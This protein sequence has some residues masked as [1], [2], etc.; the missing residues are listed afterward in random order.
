MKAT[1][2]LVLFH[3]RTFRGVLSVTFP[4]RHYAQFEG[5]TADEVY[6]KANTYLRK[7]GEEFLKNN[8]PYLHVHTYAMEVE[9]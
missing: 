2:K 9:V 8:S 6:G 1:G 3:G 7:E 4:R 5:N